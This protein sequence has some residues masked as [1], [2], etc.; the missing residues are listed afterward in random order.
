[1]AMEDSGVGIEVPDGFAISVA[2]YWSFVEANGLQKKI[3]AAL[4]EYK[5]GRRSLTELGQ[6]IVTPRS[7]GT[8]IKGRG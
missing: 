6:A 7:G 4:E 5:Q 8:G 1:M 2:A 3:A